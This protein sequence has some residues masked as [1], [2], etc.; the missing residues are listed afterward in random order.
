M[1]IAQFYMLSDYIF[2]LL[3]TVAKHHQISMFSDHKVVFIFYSGV[4]GKFPKNGSFH[5]N[6]PKQLC[7]QPGFPVMYRRITLFIR[8]M[9]YSSAI[10]ITAPDAIPG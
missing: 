10:K 3:C 6:I 9:F 5:R 4:A 7:Q 1:L 8:L 2:K